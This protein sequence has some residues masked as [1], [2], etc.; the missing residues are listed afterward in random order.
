MHVQRDGG[1]RSLE[2]VGAVSCAGTR[3]KQEL[4]PFSLQPVPKQPSED[5]RHQTAPRAQQKDD[6]RSAAV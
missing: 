5:K 2:H 6:A 4:L 1:G 3:A